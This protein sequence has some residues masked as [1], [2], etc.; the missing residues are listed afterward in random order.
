M[1]YG[2]RLVMFV[3]AV[4]AAYGQLFAELPALIARARAE[5]RA[6]RMDA[7]EGAR[8][9]ALVA[10]ARAHLVSTVAAPHAIEALAVEFARK[11]STFQRVQLNK[12]VQAALG[13]DVF[14]ADKFLASLV[15]GFASEN[16]ALITGINDRIASE[17]ET[18]VTRGLQSGTLPGDIADELDQ[19]FAFGEKRARLI[20]RDQIG[21]L[22]G[23]INA[24]RQ[25]ELGVTRFIWRTVNDERVRGAPGGKYPSADPSHDDLDGKIFEYANPPPSHH[26]GSPGLPGEPIECRC[27]AE[28]VFDDILADL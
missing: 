10:A 25:Q 7:G 11:T 14:V 26:D 15:E 1:D 28:P 8:V 24:A 6:D 23:Q 9:R 18:V 20:A 16:A 22:N 21:K 17:V 19:R 2:A 13:A 4:R 3:R 27:Y 12:Q 5:R